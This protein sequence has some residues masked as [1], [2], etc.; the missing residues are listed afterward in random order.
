MVCCLRSQET[1][2]AHTNLHWRITVDTNHT[3]TRIL[4]A[5]GS[6]NF[7]DFNA[8]FDVIEAFA[9]ACTESNVR[10]VVITTN[11]RGADTLVNAACAALEVEY[12]EVFV[13]PDAQ[14]DAAF[15]KGDY[16]SWHPRQARRADYL[17]NGPVRPHEV[18]LFE[19][20]RDIAPGEYDP[21]AQ[22][23][24]IN[25]ALDSTEIPVY[26]VTNDKELDAANRSA[27]RTGATH[28]RI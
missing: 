28:P 13:K 5:T 12:H 16:G 19:I 8:V 10:P 27:I 14:A 17:V 21:N 22:L 3:D 11:N 15:T 4:L 25:A 7:N 24:F 1:Q 6:P 2:Y 20:D 9:K 23:Q 26:R 18:A